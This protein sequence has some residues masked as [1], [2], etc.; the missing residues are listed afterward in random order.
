M[1]V[2]IGLY[3]LKTQHQSKIDAWLNYILKKWQKTREKINVQQCVNTRAQNRISHKPFFNAKTT[4]THSFS[5]IFSRKLTVSRLL[6][7]VSHATKIIVAQD[8]SL[9]FGILMFQLNI[10][11][12]SQPH[13]DSARFKFVIDS[14]S[15]LV[16]HSTQFLYFHGSY[17][18]L[19]VTQF[20]RFLYF[21]GFDSITSSATI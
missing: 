21:C 10:C 11:F 9:R 3:N 6:S 18:V 19:I 20:S 17:S 8:T 14:K 2:Y 13:C 5:K 1:R 4:K 12:S 16:V 7:S 15:V